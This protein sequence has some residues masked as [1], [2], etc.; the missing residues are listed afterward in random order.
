MLPR[1]RNNA[2]PVNQNDFFLCAISI[3]K[4]FT[5]PRGLKAY[6]N[7]NKQIQV[8]RMSPNSGGGRREHI[9][10]D[11]YKYRHMGKGLGGVD[12]VNCVSPTCLKH[13]YKSMSTT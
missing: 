5:E 9:Q 13:K 6:I 3:F 10:V 2:L 4:D 12:G 7:N 1:D 11:K 8:V